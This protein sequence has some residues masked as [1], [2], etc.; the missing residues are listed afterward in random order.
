[1]RDAADQIEAGIEVCV[2]SHDRRSLAVKSPASDTL[3]RKVDQNLL[4]FKPFFKMILRQYDTI[5][6]LGWLNYFQLAAINA[7]QRKFC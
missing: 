6:T 4:M 5:A 1:M 7:D 2:T 3:R